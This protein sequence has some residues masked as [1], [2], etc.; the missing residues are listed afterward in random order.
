MH[1]SCPAGVKLPLPDSYAGVV[2]EC[3]QRDAAT[4]PA[5]SS[6]GQGQEG[7]SLEDVGSG[8]TITSWAAT[9]TFSHIHQYNHDAAPLKGDGLRRCLEWAQLSAQV[10]AAIDPAAVV[11]AAAAQAT[12]G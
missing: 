7:T 1:P 3:R 12:A 9:G 10:H 6:Q 5:G 11:A 4:E 2:L 8:G